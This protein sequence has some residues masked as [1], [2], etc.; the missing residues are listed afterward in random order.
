M[1]RKVLF[2]CLLVLCLGM[3]AG[4]AFAQTQLNYCVNPGFETAGDTPAQAPPWSFWGGTG[5]RIA[6][7]FQNVDNPSDWVW[8]NF[9]N[10]TYVNVAAQNN[11]SGVTLIHGATYY[12]N[13]LYYV[14]ASEIVEGTTAVAA[15][16]FT[17]MTAPF[18]W[19]LPDAIGDPAVINPAAVIT[20]DAWNVI[21][22]SFVYNSPTATNDQV[23][24]GRFMLYGRDLTTNARFPN[25]GGYFDDCQFSTMGYTISGTITLS[26]LAD[27][28]GT[29]VTCT[30][31]TAPVVVGSTGDYSFVVP[32]GTY[33]VSASKTLYTTTSAVPDVVV[34]DADVPDVDIELPRVTTGTIEGTIT[35]ESGPVAGII[36]TACDFVNHSLVPTDSAPTGIDGKY[37][38]TVALA[39]PGSQGY[40]LAIKNM[41][42]GKIVTTGIT[43][44]IDPE[45]GYPYGISPPAI[46]QNFVI[47]DD[48]EYDPDP[49][50]LI[51]L[52]VGSLELGSLSSWVNKGTLGGTFD[53]RTVGTGPSVTNIGGKKCVQFAPLS[54]S[55]ADSQTLGSTVV[56]PAELAGSHAWTVVATLYKTNMAS[57]DGDNAY[58]S[59]AGWWNGN[60]KSAEFCFVNNKAVDH[61]GS[62]WGYSTIPSGSTWHNV[63]V[64]YDG[65]NETIYTDGAI[66]GTSRAIAL[67]IAAG[68]QILVGSTSDVAGAARIWNDSYWRLNGAIA[69]LKVY[70][71]ALSAAEVAALEPPKHI[72]TAS[73]DPLAPGGKITPSGDVSIAE[74]DSPTFTITPNWDK[75]ILDVVVD[76]VPQGPISSYTFDPV[77][78]THTIVAS[79]ENAPVTATRYEAELAVLVSCSIED[80]ANAS[81][82]QRVSQ[83]GYNMTE[84]PSVTFTV[85]VA[86]Q[87]MYEM[88]MGYRQP[89][90]GNR[91][92]YISV[93]GVPLGTIGAPQV[94]DP[95]YGRTLKNI[96]LKAG[97]NTIVLGNNIGWGPHWD[98]IEI[99]FDSNGVAWIV[100]ASAGEGGTISP[101]GDVG[102]ADGSSQEFIITP[103]IGYK[104]A[105]VTVDTVSQGAVSSCTVTPTADATIVAY[106]EL[107]DLGVVTGVVT[108]SVSTLGIEGAKVYFKTTANASKDADF[109]TTTLPDGSYSQS[110]PIGDWYIAAGAAG[111]DVSADQGVS[112]TT[113]GAT[114][115]FA[116][117]ANPY[118][119]VFFCA[120]VDQFSALADGDLTGNWTP[121]YVFG[122]PVGAMLTSMFTPRVVT[123][124]G[125]KWIS[126]NR[127]DTIGNDGFNLTGCPFTVQPNAGVDATGVSVVAVVQP[128]YNTTIGGEPRGEIVN[129]Y[130][131]GL[132]LCVDHATGE[133]MVARKA[134]DW[135]RTGTIIPDGQKSI[136]ALVCQLDG[137][138]KL[139]VNGAQSGWPG[140]ALGDNYY[141]DLTGGDGR[142]SWQNLIG[143]GRNV[144]DNWSSFNG[145]IGDV[146]VYKDAIS[147]EKR[148]ALQSD[149]GAKFG[150]DIPT[151][152]D[153]SGKVT[154]ED[155]IT[156]VQGALVIGGLTSPLT[157]ENG[158]YTTTASANTTVYLSA[159]KANHVTVLPIDGTY[160]VN[161]GTEDITGID[162]QMSQINIV[163]GIVTDGTNP[164]YNAVV[165]IGVGGPAAVTD[166][167]GKYT[168]IGITPAADSSVYADGL[169]WGDNTQ[170][171]DTSAAASGTITLDDIVLT[172]KTET[173]ASYIQNGGFETGDLTGWVFE[174]DHPET[175]DLGVTTADKASGSYAATWTSKTG[176]DYYH[177]YLSQ[178]IPVVAGSTYNVYFKVKTN[179]T[180][181]EGQCGFDFGDWWGYDGLGTNWMY[182]PVPGVW[183]QTLNYRLW[184]NAG[185]LTAVRVAIPEGVTGIHLIMG[186]GTTI[187]G[188][189]LY[190]DDVVVDRVGDV[191]VPPVTGPVYGA[192]NK[193]V[194]TDGML[195]GKRVKVWGKIISKDIASYV[196]SDGYSA[197]VTI[198]GTTSL[199][200]DSIAVVTGVVLPDGSVTSD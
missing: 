128:I 137:S 18:V 146:Y 144:W 74:G 97:D 92:T 72:I 39:A 114:A 68:D 1:S 120:T 64:T 93:N 194:L 79:F 71:R 119:D 98:Y 131:N 66:N 52:A 20:P 46:D 54:Q 186:L 13:A 134:W 171:I 170:T 191:Y 57:W 113:A 169:G 199:P 53:K 42:V 160:E 176:I 161:V 181:C 121:T 142:N 111:Y 85:N 24:Y 75:L 153:I 34:V 140:A 149:L 175:I 5:G 150:I 151:F 61:N 50:C 136:V 143:V 3:M 102:V 190:I 84:A 81:N 185:K 49:T 135:Q 164:I 154:L 132:S 105:D 177:G 38:V 163:K 91:D 9:G 152:V 11:M 43:Y 7:P 138:A 118:W 35:D 44:P 73:I 60:P 109:Y 78:T 193:S 133:V 40:F 15:I 16:G 33:T 110:L 116:L 21:Q 80:D 37:S 69:K 127:D 129:L 58:L 89:W 130:Y 27:P 100:N 125:V 145:N 14:P 141:A 187:A 174:G 197:G 65:A 28:T 165:Q 31:A 106:F 108:D 104:I 48:P 88:A 62:G 195:I 99:P 12:Y 94:A 55:D 30:G 162:F 115:D 47:G 59:W 77:T 107:L 76:D 51:N 63:A 10:P 155:G 26:D 123:V 103:A 56:T 23:N 86:T 29:T 159:S 184:N 17:M 179:A 178:T 2:M 82:G 200:P 112:L 182:T 96:A 36:V 117:V 158:N 124:D 166:A 32:A 173:D 157:D 156:P 22:G 188:R 189:T 6:N 87:G 183:E 4:S 67:D 126:N 148:E 180:D 172:P 192:N 70:S 25:P 19:A 167:D 45:S 95:D 41:P 139:Y 8:S 147:D 101:A 83:W 198:N 90:D 196:I 168:V 122:N